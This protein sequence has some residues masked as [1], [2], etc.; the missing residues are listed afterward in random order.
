M[1]VF[2]AIG[3]SLFG[4]GTL[5]AS[6]A[7]GALQIAAGLALNYFV[8]SLNGQPDEAQYAGMQGTLQV[9]ADLPRTVPVGWALAEP[10]LVYA[11]YWG[12]ADQTPNAYLTQVICLGDYPVKALSQLYIDGTL[13]TPLWGEVGAMGAPL[14]GKRRDGTDYA[15]VKFHDG[16]QTV[17]DAWLVAQFGTHPE[18]PYSVNRVGFGCPYLILT[19]RVHEELW[20]GFPAVKAVLSGAKLY[21]ISK[22]STRGGV[23]AQ[24]VDQPATW[25]GD[26]DELVAVQAYAMFMGVRFNGQ[27][28]YGLQNLPLAQ[29]PDA[30]WV[31]QVN[32]CRSAVTGPGGTEPAY[33][34]GASI[35]VSRPIA[36]TIKSLATSCQGRVVEVG[37]EFR[38]HVGAAGAPIYHITDDDVISTEERRFTPFY[39]LADTVNGI[40]ATHPSPGNGWNA[41][42]LP[43]LLRPD[44]EA[45]DGARRLL[46]DVSLDFVPYTWQAQ[47][48]MQQAL[49]EA[50][51]ERKL[52]LVLPGSYYL[53]LPGECITFTSVANG[54]ITK[55]FRIDGAGDLASGNVIWDIT[56]IDPD[57]YSPDFETYVP[58][59]DGPLLPPTV[60]VQTIVAGS[61]APALLNDSNGV[62]R[63]PAVQ[64]GWNPDIEDVRAVGMQLRVKA[65][66]ELIF[67]ESHD[68]VAAGFVKVA[69]AR[70]IGAQVLQ[71]RGRYYSR[72][73]LVPQDWTGWLDVTT[74]D[75]RLSIHDINDEMRKL[76]GVLPGVGSLA[77]RFQFLVDEL[78]ELANTATGN[79]IIFD[80]QLGEARAYFIEQISLVVDATQAAVDL[81]T[82][83]LAEFGENIGVAAERLSVVANEFYSQATFAQEVA[84]E[85]GGVTASAFR[86]AVVRASEIDG[87]D[88]E[89]ADM[90]RGSIDGDTYEMGR[91]MLLN[92]MTGQRAIV[93]KASE[94]YLISDDH[95]V[96]VNPW[97]VVAGVVYLTDVRITGSLIVDETIT[98]N[99]MLANAVTSGAVFTQ[100]SEIGSGAELVGGYFNVLYGSVKILFIGSQTR[101]Y[102]NPGNFGGYTITVYRD[103]TPIN[104]LPIFY[105]DNFSGIAALAAVD[106]PGPGTFYY[107][108]GTS[109]GSGMGGFTFAAGGQLILDNFK[110]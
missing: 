99:L 101:P 85:A 12:Q 78:A 102:E 36:D 38:W 29:L 44:L 91:L 5:M 41:L 100:G 90:L 95:G 109:V 3:V 64:F 77:E 98:T 33:R 1:A 63:R 86:T 24:R 31:A 65:T 72:S 9:G 96:V 2:T 69:S 61:V 25:G 46:A 74:P 89:V 92:S 97:S 47:R 60:P 67:S 42:P 30:W 107:S 14:A 40:A 84:A 23:G 82:L 13:D 17:A 94:Y 27:W 68:N 11:N 88:I 71:G 66:G 53:A 50:R 104:S 28:L 6:V 106:T 32:A 16:T 51:R 75:V 34:S 108:I 76:T 83:L 80:V 43:T 62:A 45:A 57:D 87:Y 4:A 103:G 22:D 21:D 59:V 10:S 110:R 18:R 39:G 81:T 54:F 55:L 79:T 37:G 70:I 49:A 19:T 26:G 15:W 56:E 8:S 52:T 48:V 93:D 105:D 58:P 20:T 35:P 73:G 7:A